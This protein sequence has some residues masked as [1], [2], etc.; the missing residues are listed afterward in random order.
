MLKL[1][2]NRFCFVVVIV[3]IEGEEQGGKVVLFSS[4]HVLLGLF[5]IHSIQASILGGYRNFSLSKENA[6][7]IR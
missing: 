2:T 6:K 5:T 4:W 3:C 7:Q 1:Q